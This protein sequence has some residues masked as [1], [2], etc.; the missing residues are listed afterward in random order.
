MPR[1]EIEYHPGFIGPAWALSV[2]D[3]G[4][5]LLAELYGPEKRELRVSKT[6]VRSWLSRTRAAWPAEDIWLTTP[7]EDVDSILVRVRAEDGP[8][9]VKIDWPTDFACSELVQPA[10]AVWNDLVRMMGK[11]CPTHPCEIP[12]LEPSVAGEKTADPT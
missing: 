8:T 1:V 12:C 7:D 10:F 6:V 9:T 2:Y 11:A 5:L 3:D 4:S